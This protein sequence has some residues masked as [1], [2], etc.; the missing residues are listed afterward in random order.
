MVLIIGY[1]IPNVGAI[2]RYRSIIWIFALCPMV[3][4]IDWARLSF[5]QRKK[6]QTITSSSLNP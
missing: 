5:W 3:C 2:V 4:C 6:E 1:T